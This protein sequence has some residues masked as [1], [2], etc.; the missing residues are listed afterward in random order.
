MCLTSQGVS[1]M[2]V[3][4]CWTV[5]IISLPC[6]ERNA[7]TSTASVEKRECYV[8]ASTWSMRAPS[9]AGS[10][11]QG[12]YS[13]DQSCSNMLPVTNINWESI[14]HARPQEPL[15]LV[16][17]T[18]MHAL[19]L[20]VTTVLS[21]FTT[22]YDDARRGV[23]PGTALD[24]LGISN[25]DLAV[26]STSNTSDANSLNRNSKRA[27]GDPRLAVRREDSMETIPLTVSKGRFTGPVTF[28]IQSPF[29]H[30]LKHDLGTFD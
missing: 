14:N 11:K 24:G 16:N 5:S 25:R 4:H 21:L 27:L 10:D 2:S 20:L 12:R 28:G 3:L 23:A 1:V 29:R 19:H 9:L 13:R 8:V 7:I 22:A 30:R 26:V 18:D 15:V 6:S 17:Y